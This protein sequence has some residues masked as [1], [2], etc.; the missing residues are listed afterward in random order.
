MFNTL[1]NI[2]L[3][4]IKIFNL[5]DFKKIVTKHFSLRKAIVALVCKKVCCSRKKVL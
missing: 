4:F 3:Q 5:N 1:M 2:V